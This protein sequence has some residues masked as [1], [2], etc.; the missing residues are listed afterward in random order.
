MRAVIIALLASFLTSCAT[1][2]TGY[3]Q[4]PKEYLQIDPSTGADT[5][6]FGFTPPFKDP[7]GYRYE[8]FEWPKPHAIKTVYTYRG[9]P[10][11][12]SLNQEQASR[13]KAVLMAFDWNQPINPPDPEVQILT[14]DD[15]IVTF[16][17]RIRRVSHEVSTGISDSKALSHLLT[18]LDEIEHPEAK[19]I[20]SN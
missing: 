9:L 16:Q 4:L 8:F 1:Q 3:K 7:H 13:L 6:V 10:K 5:F 18:E 2:P 15:L 20:S 14:C 12:T 11:Q 17:A 19:P